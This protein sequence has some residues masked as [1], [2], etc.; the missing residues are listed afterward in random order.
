M[1]EAFEIIHGSE[2]G[3]LAWVVYQGKAGGKTFRNA[4]LHR[5]RAGQIVETEVYFGWNIP[6]PVPSGTHIDP[7]E[8]GG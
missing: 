8:T 5:V 7:P 4:E 6:H 1:M 2:D 3:E